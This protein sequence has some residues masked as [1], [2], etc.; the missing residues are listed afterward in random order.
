M[1]RERQFSRD[2][3]PYRISR[4]LALLV[5]VCVTV[6]PLRAGDDCCDRCGANGCRMATKTVMVPMT[7]VE[8][9]MKTCVVKKTVEREETYTVFRRVPVHREFNKEVCYLDDEVKTKE[10]EETKCRVIKVPVERTIHVKVPVREIQTQM[11]RRERCVDGHK[12]IVEEPCTREVIRKTDDIRTEMCQEPQ[13]VFETNKRTI[14]YCVKVP[15]K[16]VIPCTE[17]TTYKLVPE[18]RTRTVTVCVPEIVKKPVE[19]TCTKMVP[20]TITCCPKC[21]RK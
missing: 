12:V 20:R 3:S 8:T 17:E 16:R 21:G 4:I 6:Q 2:L 13:L 14:D 18:Q 7:V 19:V 10:I 5:V 1:Y 11:V 9:R 15:K